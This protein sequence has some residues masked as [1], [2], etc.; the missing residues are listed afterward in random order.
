M[1]SG[2]IYRY[3]GIS[4]N[5]GNRIIYVGFHWQ[6]KTFII[7]VIFWYFLH[8]KCMYCLRVFI[9]VYI[10]I[11]IVLKFHIS[12]LLTFLLTINIDAC[13]YKQT[14]CIKPC[15]NQ[16]QSKHTI[17]FQWKLDEKVLLLHTLINFCL[18]PNMYKYFILWVL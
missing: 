4:S 2:Q 6:I 18:F 3:I 15:G 13:N 9:L 17:I 1:L 7:L 8:K 11:Q 5:I 10:L 12:F 16:I 14:L